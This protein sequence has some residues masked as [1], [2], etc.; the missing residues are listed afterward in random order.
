MY[1]HGEYFTSLESCWGSGEGRESQGKAEE[2]LRL[3]GIARVKKEEP[4]TRRE[5]DVVG[6]FTLWSCLGSRLLPQWRG[7]S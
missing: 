3:S 7:C 2:E 4:L 6:G 5:I 1:P